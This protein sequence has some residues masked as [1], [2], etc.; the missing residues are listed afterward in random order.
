MQETK[1]KATTDE[2]FYANVCSVLAWVFMV[3]AVLPLVIYIIWDT[4][5]SPL[6]WTFGISIISL[7]FRCLETVL[8]SLDAIRKELSKR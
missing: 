6:L 4:G 7:G 5:K 2:R 3:L 1:T 8:V